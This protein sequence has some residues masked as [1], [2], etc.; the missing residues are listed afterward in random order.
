[1]VWGPTSATPTVFRTL[2]AG[3]AGGAYTTLL[4]FN[5]PDHASQANMTPQQAIGLWP[6]LEQTGLRLGSPAPAV[7]EDGWLKAF[8]TL[9]EQHHYRVDFIALHFYVDYTDAAAIARMQATL[10]RI[11]N[12]FGKPIWITELGALDTRPW[13]EAMT[14]EPTEAR[15]VDYLAK[16]TRMLDSLPFVQRYAWFTDNCWSTPQFRLSSLYDAAGKLTPLGQAYRKVS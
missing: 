13:G 1:M 6:Q 5:E 12:E 4:G 2:A 9:A 7:A 14:S 8:M 15:A 10:T 3:K 11:H 16:T